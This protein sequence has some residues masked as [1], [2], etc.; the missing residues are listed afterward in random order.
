MAQDNLEAIGAPQ[1]IAWLANWANAMVFPICW[2]DRTLHYPK[3][4][5]VASCFALRFPDLVGVTAAHVVRTYQGEL[6]ETPDLT[7]QLRHLQDFDLD[8]ALVNID[9]DLV[10]LRMP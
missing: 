4:V 6:K 9:D 8:R 2:H 1:F 5:K 10:P 3:P 7:C